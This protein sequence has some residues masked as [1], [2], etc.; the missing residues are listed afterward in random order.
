VSF[1]LITFELKYY[2]STHTKIILGKTE[3]TDLSTNANHELKALHVSTALS[4]PYYLN[5]NLL[6]RRA[7]VAQTSLDTILCLVL[8]S[9][10]AI[11]YFY[12]EMYHQYLILILL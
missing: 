1:E 2:P 6:N 8:L 7:S 5:Q 12:I 9:A 3:I 10:H 11:V 4:K